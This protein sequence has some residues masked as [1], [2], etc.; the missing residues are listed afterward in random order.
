[1]ANPA[2]PTTYQGS[3]KLRPEELI[4]REMLGA[5]L[6]RRLEPGM[7]LIEE[8]LA[9]T[10]SVSRARIR[11]TFLQLAHDKLINLVPNRGAF[12][13]EPTINEAIEVFSA[14][15]MIED[16]VVR[17]IATHMTPDRASQIRDH[18][19]REHQAHHDGD[20][21]AAII[22]SGEF[23]LLLAR[24]AGN[25]VIEEFLERLIL[26]SSLIIAM[27]ESPQPVDCS[28]SEHE[29]L[30]NALLGGDPDVAAAEMAK[31]LDA[32]RNRLQLHHPKPAKTDFASIFGRTPKSAAS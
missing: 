28:H 6:D 14:R 31:H 3:G 16:G 30:L 21:R 25:L 8:D 10:F 5:I 22:L 9:K 29:T 19:E 15:R 17:K 23:H 27:Y 26:R 13:A 7:K 24:L 11:A 4:Y 32:I 12:I 18:L 20:H 1:M 2:P